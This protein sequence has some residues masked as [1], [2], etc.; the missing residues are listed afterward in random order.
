M[1]WSRKE[2]HIDFWPRNAQRSN[3]V[4]TRGLANDLTRFL[5]SMYAGIPL[6]SIRRWTLILPTSRR[7]KLRFLQFTNLT[8]KILQL[9]NK[10]LQGTLQGTNIM[11]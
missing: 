5:G 6:G 2:Q 4:H 1:K 8:R 7:Y 9:P 3:A 11:T 10:I